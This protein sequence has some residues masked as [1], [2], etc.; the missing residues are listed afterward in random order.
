MVDTL[1]VSYELLSD[2]IFIH[3]MSSFILTP[4]SLYFLQKYQKAYIKQVSLIQTRFVL[5]LLVRPTY[6]QL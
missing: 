5:N 2:R 3:N 4:W 1:S 6:L